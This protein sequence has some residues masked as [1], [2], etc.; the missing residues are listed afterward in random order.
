MFSLGRGPRV[1]RATFA[2]LLAAAGLCAAAVA[3]KAPQ[4]DSKNQLGPAESAYLTRGLIFIDAPDIERYLRVVIQRLLDSSQVKTPIPTILIQSSEAFDVFTDSRQNLIIS[5]GVLRELSS[6][7]ELAA[8]LG[9]EMSHQIL[10]HPQRKDAMRAVP[11]GLETAGYVSVA[12]DR[13]HGASGQNYSGN[14]GKFTEN[15]LANTQAATLLWTDILAPGWNRRQERAADENGFLLMRAAG[16]NTSAF[17][18][19]FQR[20]HA[21]QGKRS[22]RMELLGKVML[23]RVKMADAKARAQAGAGDNAVTAKFDELSTELRATL[24]EKAVGS[25]IKGLTSFNREYDSPAV[26]QQ[27]LSQFAHDHRLAGKPPVRPV[28]QLAVALRQGHGAWLL[29]LDAAAIRTLDALTANNRTAA[30]T[31]ITPLQAASPN[32]N[33]PTPHLNL[34]LGAWQEAN[35]HPEQGEARARAWL[36][37]RRPPANA[38]VWLAYHQFK[39]KEYSNSMAT[40]ERGRRKIGNG[41]PFLP[42]L[43][44]VAHTAGDDQRA[45]KYVLECKAEDGKNISASIAAF[46]GGNRVPSGLYADCVQ[47]LGHEPKSALE[48]NALMQTLK[49]PIEG[50]KTLAE[51]I[52]NKFRKSK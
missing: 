19:L 49:H 5:T 43:V 6:E 37:A 30:Q 2:G 35:G 38:Y 15:S 28:S 13:L 14:L 39:R 42:H 48:S 45:E 7:D 23:A 36:T 12:A 17:G 20:L 22:A 50:S 29:A 27:N 10:R 9:H 44:S 51:K 25:V 40:M 4:E 21:E 47:R 52:R 16:Y 41:A 34:A 11:L 24:T 33:P 46:F 32:G 3:A 18:S 26:R 31:A 8:L 1:A